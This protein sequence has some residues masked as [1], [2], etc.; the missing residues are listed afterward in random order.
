MKLMTA[1]WHPGILHAVLQLI[2]PSPRASCW[3]GGKSDHPKVLAL[4]QELVPSLRIVS[5]ITSFSL[6]RGRRRMVGHQYEVFVERSFWFL[7]KLDLS[8]DHYQD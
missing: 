8:A 5:N 3:S 2:S 6:R 7:P 1:V 4:Y